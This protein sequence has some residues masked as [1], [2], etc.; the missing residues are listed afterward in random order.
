[1]AELIQ[2]PCPAC[3]TTL[4]LPLAMAAQKGPCPNCDR[5]IIAP[6][7]F[8]GTGAIIAPLPPPPPVPEPF[9]PFADPPREIPQEKVSQEEPA[10]PPAADPPVTCVK[11]QRLI[12]TLSCLLSGTVGILI[13][14]TAQRFFMR[15][16]PMTG[17]MIP[18]PAAAPAIPAPVQAPVPVPA[19]VPA[20][21]TPVPEIPKIEKQPEPPEKVSAA[22]EAALKA[23]LD[24]PD[25]AARTSYVLFPEKVRTAMEAYSREVPDGPTVYQSIIVKQSQFDESSGSTLFIFLVTTERHPE[26]IPVAVRET[27][28]GWLVDWLAFVEFRDGLFQK[29][30][31]GPVDRT[32]YFHLIVT[33]PPAERAANTENEHF[34]S[35]L[36]QPPLAGKPQIAF[37]KKNSPAFAT[38]QAATTGGTPFT[39]ILEVRKSKTTDGQ[40][41]FE[42]TAVKAG[43]WFPRE[44]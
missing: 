12:F 33:Q 6:D 35:Y 31:D 26:G 7:P 8:H 5:E 17:P 2:F 22:A 40:S 39:P 28:G 20:V 44:N 13:G 34:S 27:T 15:V 29:F 32:G 41:Y 18:L 9:I 3:G 11:P 25:W 43:D 16:P 10:P 14:L 23:F 36:L 42:V 21:V 37:V 30:V 38:I 1:M 24:A 4:R 19:P